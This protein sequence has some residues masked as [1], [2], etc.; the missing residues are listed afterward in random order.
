MQVFSNGVDETLSEF[1]DFHFAKAEY[2]LKFVKR[3][4]RFV[5]EVFQRFVGEYHISG[6][7]VFVGDLLADF[8]QDFE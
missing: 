2:V 7:V 4:G 6:P 1:F 8:S 5:G 3:Q